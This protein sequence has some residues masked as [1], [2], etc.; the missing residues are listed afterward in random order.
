LVRNV[1]AYSEKILG[2]QNMKQ[3]KSILRS[4]QFL[5]GLLFLLQVSVAYGTEVPAFPV[6]KQ[7]ASFTVGVPGSAEAQKYLGLKSD[8]PF[9]MADLQTKVVVIEFMNAF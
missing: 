1:K 2:G 7:I 3:N 5:A 4:L 6:G 9:K 8:V